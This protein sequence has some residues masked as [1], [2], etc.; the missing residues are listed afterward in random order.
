M[1]PECIQA[2]NRALGR[3]AT[4]AE[5]R[6]IENTIRTSM[7]RLAADDPPGWSKL[8]PNERLQR[9]AHDASEGIEQEAAKRRQRTALAILAHDRMRNYID[10]QVA[11]GHDASGVDALRR[12]LVGETDGKNN[13]ASVYNKTNG[14]NNS[15]STFMAKSW[16]LLDKRLFGLL[17]DP[18]AE[19]ELLSALYGDKRV[20]PQFKA[21]ADDF[22]E[23]AEM[24][25]NQMNAA[26]GDIGKLDNWGIP[27]SWSDHLLL[28]A[29]KQ[30][31]TDIM[32]PLLNRSFYVHEDGSAYSDAEMRTFL[33]EAWQTVV[34]GGANKVLGGERIG[35]GIKANRGSA[36]RQIHLK[37]APS[38]MTAMRAFSDHSVMQSMLGHLK[39]MARNTALIEQFG[40]N[41]DRQFAHF[42]EQ[43]SA[44]SIVA[45]PEN[46]SSVEKSS[47]FVE[48]LY[49]YMAGNGRPPPTTWHGKA[50]QGWR[51]LQTLKL[52]SVLVTA[53]TDNAPMAVTAH[54]N[55][56]PKTKM[57][58]NELGRLNPL[59]AKA[60]QMAQSAGLMTRTY[61]ESISRYG[62]DVGA[63]G[64]TSKVGAAMLKLSGVTRYW[65]AERFGFSTGMLN[66][67][68]YALQHYDNLA[69]LDR[70][71]QKFI[72]S[73]GMTED[74]WKILKLA[75][76]DDYGGNHT[77]ITPESIYQIPEADIAAAVQGDPGVIRNQAAAHLMGFVQSEQDN[78][79]LEPD[80]VTR[81]KSGADQSLDG[82]S[83]FL[84]SSYRLFKSYPMQMLRSHWTR[85]AGAYETKAGTAGYAA[86]LIASTI[87]TG[88]I[89]NS[90]NDILSGKDPRTLD[91]SSKE[92]W[93]NWA[94]ALAKGGGLGIYGDFLINTA[95]ARGNT[96]AETLLGPQ[97]ADISKLLN[98]GQTLV[99]A[100]TDP[101][102]ST[103]KK[104]QPTGVSTVAALKSYVPGSSLWY[105]KA[106]FNHLIFN[107]LSDYLSPGY[108]DRMKVK[109]RQQG[110]SAWWEPDQ[111]TPSRAPDLSHVAADR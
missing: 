97:V 8:S 53:F 111:A 32:L 63:H 23:A 41:A 70:S 74:D 38:H 45:D 88:A 72:K 81:V 57:F 86:A 24:A 58:L 106:A 90:V 39:N 42:L 15:W 65:E 87:V 4:T 13:I 55:G 10:A 107:Q 5:T 35:S 51:N 30:K 14:Y 36:E 98:V 75:K 101:N 43:E 20:S 95:E 12:M 22:H 1:R 59:N 33:G 19:A 85:A 77:L 104:L 93:K 96:L 102:A 54:V 26:G 108:L 48:R 73:S 34:T 91:L 31:W 105:L 80:P 99:S 92:G 44:R 17:R 2:V 11:A 25:R 78:A 71:D 50:I 68:G 27:Q 61:N 37:D 76:L 64:W 6:D 46:R 69:D 60:K 7:R 89:A 103:V 100:S 83:A 40:P 62:G 67:V 84:V 56:I 49:N 82:M 29:G 28:K 3:S 109:A 47:R 66:Q 18:K 110:H 79:I 9:A 52:G 94:A 16:N 21:A